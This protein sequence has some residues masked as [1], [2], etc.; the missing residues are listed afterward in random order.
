MSLSKLTQF[1]LSHPIINLLSY[2][3]WDGFHLT[4]LWLGDGL[5]GLLYHMFSSIS[6][7]FLNDYHGIP[8]WSGGGAIPKLGNSEM[9]KRMTYSK[10]QKIYT[11][12]GCNAF[13]G[14][15]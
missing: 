10:V 13:K 8:R 1:L 12:K 11:A 4:H 3:S 2:L 9:L 14:S 15:E 5:L 7:Y 6:H